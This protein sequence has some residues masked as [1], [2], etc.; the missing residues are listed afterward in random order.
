MSSLKNKLKKGQPIIGTML[1]L[2]D[3]PD[4]VKLLKV[5]EFDY[6]IV[7]CEHST[8]DF[9]D[10]AGLLGMA[11]AIGLPG[12]VRIPEAKREVVL[13]YIEAGAAGFLLP[14]TETEEQAKALVEY[15]KYAPMGNRGISLFR[16]HAG[17]NKIANTL[18]YMEKANNETILMVQI[19]SGKGV[20]NVENILAIEGIDVAFIGP[21]DLSQSLGIMGQYDN[22]LF[23]NSVEKVIR[24][25]KGK[26]KH[27]GI[28]LMD[29]EPLQKWIGKGMTFNLVFNELIMMTNYAKEN[30]KKLKKE[31]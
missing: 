22:P 18:E 5:C 31:Y 25:A 10:V 9:K 21:N 24:V 15:S 23:I 8:Y 17:Y 13:K 1:V 30:L 3:N 28:H 20:D 29:V 11:K 12:I 14:N 4:I 6:F 2:M 27:A 26:G 19:E 16:P 7:D